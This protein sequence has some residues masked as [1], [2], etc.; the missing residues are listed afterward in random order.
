VGL[1]GLAVWW[2]MNNNKKESAKEAFD[3][4]SP[5]DRADSG[6]NAGTVKPPVAGA[7]K[8]PAD[9]GDSVVVK[10]IPAKS[11]STEV[12]DPSNNV[13]DVYIKPKAEIPPSSA[14]ISISKIERSSENT[15]VSFM[16]K[17]QDNDNSTFSIYGPEKQSNCF[18]LESNGQ[19]YKLISIYPKGEHL[20]FGS[21]DT[22][23]FNAVFQRIPDDAKV[24]NI[25]EGADRDRMNQNYWSFLKVHLIK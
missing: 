6:K 24:I 11:K 3:T 21:S 17:R 8:S 12:F 22:F 13:P 2:V 16:L 5:L 18:F 25:V 19:I 14:M 23:T 15:I 7:I 10:K 9:K 1:A 20:T 4:T